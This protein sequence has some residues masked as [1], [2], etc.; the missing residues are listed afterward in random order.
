MKPMNRFGI[1]GSDAGTIANLNKY[2]TAYE[3]WLEKTG[4]KEPFN[5]NQAT[6]WGNALENIVAEKYSERTGEKLRK[7]NSMF[8]HKKYKWM[9]GNV[10]RVVVGKK[11]LIEIK[12]A[13]GKF[14]SDVEWGEDGSDIV[15]EIYF[16]QIQHYLAVTG[17][18]EADLAAL[19]SGN[20]GAELRIYNIKK[21]KQIIDKLIS[22]ESD[23]WD[24][25]ETKT[26]PEIK[27]V[28]DASVRWRQDDGRSLIASSEIWSY[29][30]QLKNLKDNIKILE[31]Q[32]DKLKLEVM[33]FMGD[34]AFLT[35]Q[36][37]SKL[38]SWITQKSNR[39]D[40]KAIKE[41]LPEIAEKYNKPSESRVF[42]V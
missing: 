40:T 39:I 10:D 29:V 30:Q 28:S 27:S 21:D 37:G 19:V 15:P 32:E 14:R 7:S 17:Y 33:N 42:R 6:S 35:D 34:K 24:K 11:K 3:L 23:F 18:Q 31:S 20:A 2:K 12:T 22:M 25:V 1:G 36:S 41:E 4:Q 16:C 38:C 26:P 9:T 5:G 8:V 13:L